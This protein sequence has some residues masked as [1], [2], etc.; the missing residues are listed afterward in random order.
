MK[1][2]FKYIP[3]NGIKLHTALAGPESGEPVILLHGFP[4]AWFGWEKQITALAEAG[5]R[6]I[7]PDQRGY[8][9]SDKPAGVESYQVKSLVK[10]IIGLAKALDLDSFHLAGH[11][12]GAMVAWSLASIV[13]RR[14]KRLVIA[15]VPHPEVFS[16]YLRSHPSQMLKSWYMFFFQLP[17]IPE[18]FVKSSNWNFLVSALPGYWGEDQYSRYREA[19]SQPGAITAMI[20]WYRASLGRSRGSVKPALVEPETLIIWGKKDPHLS[21]QMAGLSLELCRQG[22]LVYLEDASHWVQHDKAAQVSD[23]LIDHYKGV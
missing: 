9:L 14:I 4:E 16:S 7:A 19:W 3:T 11:D 17:G 15:N 10:D 13:P 22:E 18:G 23:L 1:I 6:V 12:W 5:F 20:N 2:E 21:W 8:N